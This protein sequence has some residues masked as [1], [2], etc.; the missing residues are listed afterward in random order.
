MFE[1]FNFGAAAPDQ[2]LHDISPSP[3]DNSFPLS[4]SLPTTCPPI[5]REMRGTQASINDIMSRLRA[6]TIQ[7][8]E[9]LERAYQPGWTSPTSAPCEENSRTFSYP[10]RAKCSQSLPNIHPTP[11][12][13]SDPVGCRRLQ[14][15][16]NV[17]LQSSKSHIRDVK[18]LVEEMIMTNSQCVLREALSRQPPPTP[19]PQRCELLVD[20]MVFDERPPTL[21]TN[22]DEGFHE[23][24]DPPLEEKFAD[25]F[26][27]RRACTP[28]GIRKSTTTPEWARGVD[29]IVAGGRVLVR[30]IPRMRKRRSRP[31]ASP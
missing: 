25:K 7:S 5:D 14:R 12:P 26:V 22:I 18:A 24:E 16:L 6:Q 21:D 30:S 1:H 4:I 29:H 13:R 9:D 19:P 20:P 31:P 17:Q 11:A 2:F 8:G 3:T 28:G 27:Y 23:G 15:Q 10:S